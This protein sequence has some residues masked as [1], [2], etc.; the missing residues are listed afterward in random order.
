MQLELKTPNLALR[1]PLL[2]DGQSVYLATQPDIYGIKFDGSVMYVRGMLG[3]VSPERRA[4]EVA[5]SARY[6]KSRIIELAATINYIRS[7]GV[8]NFANGKSRIRHARRQ[9]GLEY[10]RYL[11]LRDALAMY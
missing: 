7:H 9:V 11:A 4:R 8:T 5:N 2:T 1:C 10:V 6:S 3:T